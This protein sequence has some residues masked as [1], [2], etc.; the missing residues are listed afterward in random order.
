MWVH[1]DGVIFANV[2][3]MSGV[4]KGLFFFKCLLNNGFNLGKINKLN[5]NRFYV[6]KHSLTEPSE[7]C[8]K[9][10]ATLQ[11]RIKIFPTLC[12]IICKYSFV[13]FFG[14]W[15]IASCITPWSTTSP[16]HTPNTKRESSSDSWNSLMKMKEVWREP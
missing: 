2:V 6:Q 7:F 8:L 10:S 16:W 4:L 5:R 3:Q 12:E 9:Y 13:T 1:C 15:S 11:L 14:F